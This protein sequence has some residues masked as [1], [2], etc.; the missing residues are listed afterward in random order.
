MEIIMPLTNGSNIALASVMTGMSQTE[1]S[2]KIHQS[3]ISSQKEEN[4]NWAIDFFDKDR[5][6]Y[7]K[8]MINVEEIKDILPKDLNHK[9]KTIML[10]GWIE[11]EIP[12]QT[13]SIPMELNQNYAKAHCIE[14]ILTNPSL[15]NQTIRWN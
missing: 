5:Q 11:Q 6:W 8:I 7:D 9:E 13:F 1:L 12:K 15:Y 4:I 2:E 14:L 3:K 10:Y